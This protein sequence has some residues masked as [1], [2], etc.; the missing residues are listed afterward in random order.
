M[1]FHLIYFFHHLNRTHYTLTME[2][3]VEQASMRARKEGKEKKFLCDV[4]LSLRDF[5]E[6]FMF[7]IKLI[8]YSHRFL[9]LLSFAKCTYVNALASSVT[10][11]NMERCGKGGKF[12]EQND[13]K[14][15]H[16]QRG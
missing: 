11:S 6:K 2:A 9:L 14:S 1:R 8:I 15:T 5:E 4:Q 7:E 12:S 3:I 16:T 13:T 10:S